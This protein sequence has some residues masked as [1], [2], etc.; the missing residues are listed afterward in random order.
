MHDLMGPDALVFSIVSPNAQEN[1]PGVDPQGTCL[2]LIEPVCGGKTVQESFHPV[3]SQVIAGQMMEER[4]RVKYCL[5]AFGFQLFQS[6]G[7]F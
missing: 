1:V 7:L 6:Q 5:F 4:L 3:L 2:P